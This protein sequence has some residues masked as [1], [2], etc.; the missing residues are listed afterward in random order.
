MEKTPINVKHKKNDYTINFKIKCIKKL[1]TG[2]SIHQVA[3]EAGIDRASIRD[4]IKQKDELMKK[5]Y[6]LNSFRMQGAGKKPIT[7]EL[8]E[9]LIKFILECRH[10]RIALISHKI[11]TKAQSLNNSLDGK[12]YKDLMQWCYK[13]LKRAGF[14]IRK[15]THIGQDL[16]ENS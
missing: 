4:S 2:V 6:K 16:K 9:E 10:Q 11:I 12:S 7:K 13:F 5:D 8:E 15:P 14:S 1:D 3:E